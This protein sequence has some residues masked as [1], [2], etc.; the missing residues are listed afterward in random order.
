MNFI[1][2]YCNY[3]L[4]F[5]L[6]ICCLFL[7]LPCGAFIDDGKEILTATGFQMIFG[8]KVKSYMVLSFSLLGFMM[9]ILISIAAT[10]PVFK[11]YIGKLY[12]YIETSLIALCS[13]LYFCLPLIVNHQ[14]IYVSNNFKGL[15]FLY[16]GASLLLAISVCLF[17]FER[18]IN[19]SK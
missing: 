7:F 4:L 13:I 2:K 17:F 16:I 11:K 10:L 5:L 18:K 19:S 8:L 12:V 15:V 1:N 3:I 6:I 9:L 14:V